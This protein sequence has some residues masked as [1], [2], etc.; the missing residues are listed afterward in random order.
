[1]RILDLRRAGAR[2]INSF[3]SRDFD[4]VPLLRGEAHVAVARLGPG[5]RIG[6]HPAVVAQVLVVVEGTA[7][8][9]GADG[10]PMDLGPGLAALWE[11]GEE[12]ETR[13]EHGLLAVIVEGDVG[14]PPG[15]EAL[16][17]I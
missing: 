6:R 14:Q 2:P 15:P 12:H 3:D 8:V 9:S 10:A 7:R 17:D 16:R 11:A 1:M 5:G 4:L 13:T